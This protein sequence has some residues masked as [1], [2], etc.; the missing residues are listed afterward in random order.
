MPTPGSLDLGLFFGLRIMS[1]VDYLKCCFDAEKLVEI[2]NVKD[3]KFACDAQKTWNNR[4]V[5]SLFIN[6]AQLRYNQILFVEFGFG[7]SPELSY[8]HPC[9]LL[10]YDNKL[11]KVVPITS[12]N[13]IVNVAFHPVLNPSGNKA[14]FLLPTGTCG[15]SKPSA[16]YIRQVRTI[17]ES[18]IIKI[19]DA[20]GLPKDLYTEIRN[21]VFADIFPDIFYKQQKLIEENQN[22]KTKIATL[23]K[24]ES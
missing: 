8:S 21:L 3:Q 7:Y 24:S 14:F 20:N 2:F 6:R 1:F 19:I 18:R 22:L 17:S 13:K 16:L 11:C 23:N 9:L 10:S 4:H 5:G 15:L 12:S